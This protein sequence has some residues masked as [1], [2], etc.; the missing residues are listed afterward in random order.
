MTQRKVL[1]LSELTTASLAEVSP[2]GRAPPRRRRARAA[3]RDRAVRAAPRRPDHQHPHS[4]SSRSGRTSTVHLVARR[5]SSAGRAP[6]AAVPTPSSA[7][8]PPSPPWCSPAPSSPTPPASGPRSP[9]SGSRPPATTRSRRP[10]PRRSRSPSPRTRCSAPTRSAGTSPARSGP[11]PSTDD[12]TTGDGLVVP[13]Q[14]ER[15]ADPKGPAA[16]V[17]TFEPQRRRPRPPWPRPRP[18]RSSANAEGAPAAATTRWS[19]GSPGARDDRAQLL[20]TQAG[21]RRRRRGDALQPASAGTSPTSTIGRRRRPHRAVHDHDADPVDRRRPSRD[22]RRRP[23]LARHAPSSRPLQPARRPASCT[24]PAGP[25]ARRPAGAG[26][27]RPGD[28]R[29]GRPA[30]RRRASTSPGSAPSRARPGT[31]LA[32]TG[33]DEADFSAHDATT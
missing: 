13:C 4:S 15:Y 23:K 6:R 17:R 12:N 27:G 32:A 10:S 30:A 2:R 3:D 19:T 14:A 33:C 21:R 24:R 16:L 22:W 18:A 31:T 20:R 26:R 8:P 25:D 29:R 28:A 7:S 11:S 1:L 9:A 5:R